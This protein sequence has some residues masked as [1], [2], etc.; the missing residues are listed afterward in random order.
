MTYPDKQINLFNYSTLEF[1]G[2]ETADTEI[3]NNKINSKLIEFKVF[4]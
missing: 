3:I 4:E 1:V 2:N